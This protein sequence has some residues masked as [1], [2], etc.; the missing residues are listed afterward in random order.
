MATEPMEVLDRLAALLDAATPGP[1]F[2]GKRWNV[3]GTHPPIAP[4]RPTCCFCDTSEPAEVIPRSPDDD[5]NWKGVLHRHPS[6]DHGTDPVMDEDGAV[7]SEGV[8]AHRIEGP[9]GE[10]V[11]CNYDYESGGVVNIHD[12]ELIVAIRNAAPALIRLARAVLAADDWYDKDDYTLKLAH[13]ERASAIKALGEV[14]L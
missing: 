9:K 11:C 14:R 13:D 8:Y 1:W 4:N 2:R 7:S 10:P 5:R 12:A 3:A 6:T